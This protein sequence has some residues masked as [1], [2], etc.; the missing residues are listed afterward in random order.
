MFLTVTKPDKLYPTIILTFI[1]TIMPKQFFKKYMPNADMIKKHKSLQFLGEKLNDPNLWHLNRRSV[2]IAFAV[3]L[4]FAWIPTPLQMAM[5]AV[6]AVYF[7]GNLP[8]AIALVWVTNPMTMPPLFYFA[9][10]L[11]LSVLNLPSVEFSM[12]T[13]LSGDI[14][15]PFLTGCLILAVIFSTAG[16][17]AIQGFWRYY[18][19]KKWTRQQLKR[20]RKAVNPF[21]AMY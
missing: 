18:I 3:G 20:G 12:A 2:S 6:G 10:E 19:G 14:L 15:I 1:V 4:F 11:G 21:R 5:A 7:R 8:I 16:Y 13:V 9:Y 17:F